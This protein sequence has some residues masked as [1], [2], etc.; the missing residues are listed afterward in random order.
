MINKKLFDYLILFIS[1]LAGYGCEGETD[2]QVTTPGKPTAEISKQAEC[3]NESQ[4]LVVPE[5]FCVTEIA[6]TLGTVKNLVIRDNKDIY[7]AL[8][9]RRLKLGGVLGLRDT[10]GDGKID[11]VSRV[12]DMP[13]L[14]LAIY[15]DHLYFSTDTTLYRQ[16]LSPNQL[17]PANSPEVVIDGFPKQDMHGGKAFVINPAGDLFINVGAPSNNCAGEDEKMGQQPCPELE[18]QAS[19]WKFTVEKTAQKFPHDGQQYARGVRNAYAIDWHTRSNKLFVVQH[20]RDKLHELW[21][22]IYSTEKEALLPAEEL[23]LIGQGDVFAWPYCYY[24]Q[25]LDKMIRAP[26]YGGDG[27]SNEGCL[28]YPKPL[29]AFPGHYGP[30]ALR[31]YSGTEFPEKYHQGAFIAFHGAVQISTGKLQH[32][33]V[34][35][36]PFNHGMPGKNWEIFIDGFS[37]PPGSELGNTEYRPTGL[38]IGPQGALYVVD[39]TQGKIWKIG[40]RN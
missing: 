32:N 30:N 34:I 22:E 17:I 13:T 5:G 29:V 40:Y 20:G 37:G 24:D 25:V 27:H 8:R 28:D 11:I 14:G 2:S 18:Y 10:D 3:E 19:I 38:A 12:H 26:E 35:F 9:N 6:N 16:R 36:I 4:E 31:F 33:Q 21:P 23:L 7:V 39:S 1:C 15:G